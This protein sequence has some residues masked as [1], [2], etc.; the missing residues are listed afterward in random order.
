MEKKDICRVLKGLKGVK[1]GRYTYR[2]VLV[3]D[4]AHEAGS[5]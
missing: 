3:G 5:T 2:D 1:N 4:I